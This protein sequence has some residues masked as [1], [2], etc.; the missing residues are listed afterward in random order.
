MGD[1]DRDVGTL[2]LAASQRAPAAPAFP[3]IGDRVG[4]FVVEARLGEGGMGVVL[5]AR[6]P[7]L[8]RRVAL[9]LLRA[10]ADSPGYRARL[11]REAQALARLHHPNVVSVYEI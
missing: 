4:R 3:E 10:G 8:D 1:G 5:A 2:S 6:D 11:V 7:D 9:K